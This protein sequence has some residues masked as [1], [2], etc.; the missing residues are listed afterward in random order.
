VP[1]RSRNA[2]FAAWLLTITRLRAHADRACQGLLMEDCEARA[3]VWTH[4]RIG[5]GWGGAFVGCGSCS[6]RGVTGTVQIRSSGSVRSV[7]PARR[8]VSLTAVER[9]RRGRKAAQ[10]PECGDSCAMHLRDAADVHWPLQMI[11]TNKFLK[12]CRTI[13]RLELKVT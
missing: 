3:G 13:P 7:N 10:G 4:L 11:A 9:R 1:R 6:S 2:A 12:F 5:M 8:I